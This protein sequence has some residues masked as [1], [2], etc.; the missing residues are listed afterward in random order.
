MLKKIAI[1]F[2]HKNEVKVHPSSFF[3]IAVFLSPC[4]LHKGLLKIQR[5][6]IVAG[7]KM[8]CAAKHCK[9]GGNL[10]NKF[11]ERATPLHL[12]FI[13]AQ[14]S[15]FFFVTNSYALIKFLYELEKR[16]QLGIVFVIFNV[17]FDEVSHLLRSHYEHA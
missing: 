1:K 7:C 2:V 13:S 6:V 9:V 17:S 8:I 11:D 16:S 15:A 12:S 4:Y 3:S 14:V 5:H 10:C